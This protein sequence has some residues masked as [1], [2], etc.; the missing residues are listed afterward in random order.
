MNNKVFL[1]SPDD[2]KAKS[3]INY[4]VDD[5]TVGT[6]IRDAQSIYLREIIGDKLLERLQEMVVDDSIDAEE[7]AAYLDLLDNYITEFLSY[8]ANVEICMPISMKIRNIGVSQ[9]SDTNITAAQLNNIEHVRDYYETQ[10]CDKANRMI[11]FLLENKK[12]FPELENC[13]CGHGC[14]SPNLNKQVNTNLW[15]GR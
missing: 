8:K 1:I 15:L 14:K 11:C 3:Q 13:G 5:G 7:N 12:A 9:D 6:A 10:A 2:V 4:N